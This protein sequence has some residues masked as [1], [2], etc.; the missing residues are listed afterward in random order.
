MSLKVT[1]SSLEEAA[2]DIQT[3]AGLLR[4]DLEDIQQEVKKVADV[5]K[6]EAHDAYTQVQHTWDAKANDIQNLLIN[7][8]AEIRMASGD[9]SA[10][11]KKA[12]GMF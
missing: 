4:A 1:Y 10:T 3:Q 11:D 2:N 9:Y 5:W 12:A 7:I 8:A 6:G